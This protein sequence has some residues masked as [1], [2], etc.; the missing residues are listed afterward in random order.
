MQRMAGLV[1]N[2]LQ[3]GL[4]HVA[5]NKTQPLDEL[6]TQFLQP[7]T[8]R[9]LRAPLADP[10][11][12]PT[13]GID[14]VDHGQE[15]VGAFAMSPVN[16]VHADRFD[17]AQLAMGQAPLHKPLHR[18][19]HR[20]PTG[21]KDLRRF[22]PAQPSRPAGE[23]SHHGHS[24]RPLA[25]TPGNMLNHDSVLL[26]LH[27]SW[28]VTEADRY[29]PQRYK[30]PVALRQ[31]V[32]ARSRKPALRAA[33]PHPTV[34]RQGD[35]DQRCISAQC[36]HPHVLVDESGKPLHSVQDG[37]NLD[38]NS[39]SL[40]FNQSLSLQQQTMRHGWR[41]AV[42]LAGKSK[43]RLAVVVAGAVGE[44]EIP[45]LLRDFQARW[46]S[47]APWDFSSERLLPPT[48]SP[49]NSAIEPN[50]RTAVSGAGLIAINASPRLT[51]RM[52]MRVAAKEMPSPITPPV[53]ESSMV[54]IRLWRT[55]RARLEP[56]ASRV[57]IS[58]FR[59]A[60]RARRKFARLAHAMSS[61]N[62]T[63]PMR[64]FSESPY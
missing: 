54:S 53:S 55:M 59:V 33:C 60:A 31:P 17:P 8:K 51:K 29:P 27:P 7:A 32:I 20:F 16:L 25:V 48:A 15:V 26:A 6:W 64:I 3:I 30:I 28:R 36:A 24:H 44:V 1:G 34:R 9:F 11:Q 52:R 45:K 56:R 4:P 5:A 19:I 12:A 61:T 58:R 13:T 62:A 22:P 42:P 35:L 49:T 21:L 47:P 43:S 41:S 39:R 40:L 23:K 14:L 50:N 57:A 46:K 37:L 10:Q 38:L 18:P 2:D 63:T